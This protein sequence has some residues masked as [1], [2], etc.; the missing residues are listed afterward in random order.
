[1]WTVLLG[2]VV[3]VASTRGTHTATKQDPLA[4]KA[5]S[6]VRGISSELGTQAEGLLNV[7][8]NLEAVELNYTAEQDKWEKDKTEKLSERTALEARLA[9]AQVQQREAN[10]YQ[11]QAATLR[12]KVGD[13]RALKARIEEQTCADDTLRQQQQGQNTVAVAQL[14][15]RLAA[16]QT[17]AGSAQTVQFAALRAA[18]QSVADLESQVYALVQLLRTEQQAQAQRAAE[19]AQGQADLLKGNIQQQQNN[20][21]LET[22]LLKATSQVAHVRHLEQQRAQLAEQTKQ[23]AARV[24]AEQQSCTYEV[25]NLENQVRAVQSEYAMQAKG[26]KQCQA[27]D[28]EGQRLTAEL[29]ACR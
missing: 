24:V 11:N 3:A 12:T 13:E 23:T 1:M 7:Q 21:H 26:I 8:N 28:A 4:Y 29:A 16:A 15:G 5:W 25:T 18:R 22:Q 19:R 17:A 9:R 27:A 6:F 14:Q 2:T 10:G 20:T